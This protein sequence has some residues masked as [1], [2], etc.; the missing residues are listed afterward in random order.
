MYSASQYVLDSRVRRGGGD[1]GGGGR[2]QDSGLRLATCGDVDAKSKEW[3]NAWRGRYCA[4]GQ[5]HSSK[6]M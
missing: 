4:K 2:E 5:M 6:A 1:D 3:A